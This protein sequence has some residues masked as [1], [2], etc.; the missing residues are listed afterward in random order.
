M[1]FLRKICAVTFL[2]ILGISVSAVGNESAKAQDKPVEKNAVSKQT[3]R[4]ADLRM[5]GTSCADCVM[6]IERK[7]NK[8][9]GVIKAEVSIFT[10]FPT[11][12][13]YDPA[14]TNLTKIHAALSG[15]SVKFGHISERQID[16]V[17]RVLLPSAGSL[18]GKT[19]H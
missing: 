11:I 1:R 6:R 8:V 16:K 3:L 4:R 17:P 9:R 13:I 14:K 7:I 2:M 19:Y 12:I 5:S 15:E 18:G 10:P